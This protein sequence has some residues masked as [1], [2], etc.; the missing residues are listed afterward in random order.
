MNDLF[1][2]IEKLN[3]GDAFYLVKNKNKTPLL[4]HKYDA[5]HNRYIAVPPETETALRDK[6]FLQKWIYPGERVVYVSKE[7]LS[8]ICSN[9]TAVLSECKP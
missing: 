2:T 4:L 8:N 3:A 9:T 5:M 1:T 6:E 7:R